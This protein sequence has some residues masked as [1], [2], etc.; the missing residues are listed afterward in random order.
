MD[1]EGR[2]EEVEDSEEHEKNSMLFY[3]KNCMNFLAE[4]FRSWFRL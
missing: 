3:V 1:H 2:Q 4:T